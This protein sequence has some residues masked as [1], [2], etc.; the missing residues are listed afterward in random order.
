MVCGCVGDLNNTDTIMN[1]EKYH[2]ILIHHAKLS[3]VWGQ[4]VANIQEDVADFSQCF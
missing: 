2:Q 4:K 1:A 3:G